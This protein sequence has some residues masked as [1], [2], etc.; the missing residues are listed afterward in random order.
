M[1]EP[2][3]K[4]CAIKSARLN[5]I[6]ES[7]MTRSAITIER[8]GAFE[9]TVLLAPGD[10]R[11]PRLKQVLEGLHVEADKHPSVDVRT[12]VR[13]ECVDGTTRTI[14]GTRTYEGRIV[15]DVDGKMISTTTPL[16]KELDALAKSA[17]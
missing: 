4:M 17:S 1:S 15:L 11:L 9:P 16:R 6:D 12:L 13:I 2:S 8:A 10:T 3:L 14:A 5:L 7:V